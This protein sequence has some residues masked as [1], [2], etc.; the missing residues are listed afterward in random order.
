MLIL[1]RDIGVF[2]KLGLLLTL[3]EQFPLEREAGE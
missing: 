1:L 2:E 3:G